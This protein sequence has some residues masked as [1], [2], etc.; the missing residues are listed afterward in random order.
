MALAVGAAGLCSSGLAPAQQE[1]QPGVPSQVSDATAGG[2]P[3]PPGEPAGAASK[4][5][6]AMKKAQADVERGLTPDYTIEFGDTDDWL[7]F[8]TGEWLRGRLRWVRAK[9]LEAGANVKFYSKQLYDETFG[10]SFVESIHCP[11]IMTY[12]FKGNISVSGKGMVTTNQVIIE[13]EQG[14]KTYPRSELVSIVDGA[15][16][17]RTWWSTQLSLGF[18]ANAGNTNQGSVNT[19][20]NL[21]RFDGRTAAYIGYNGSVGYADNA[22]NVN[23]H[24]VDF[25]VDLFL[26]PG[27]F[28]VIPIIGQLLYDE[29]QNYKLRAAPAAGG[30]VH[31][32]QKAKQ[33]RKHTNKFEWDI[34]SAL[35]YQFTRFLSSAT[36]VSNPQNDGF[37]MLRTYWKLKFVNRDV[38]IEIDWRTILVYT[39]FGNTN[40]NGT[41][42]VTIKITDR[43]DFEPSFLFLRTRDPLP[44]ADGTVPE[45]ND[46]QL[47]VSLALSLG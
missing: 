44:R 39:T 32:F 24:L 8:T 26:W 17:E 41:A 4:V 11:N 23:R 14:V 36:G 35:G 40:H 31:V 25:S 2:A 19:Q 34:E 16:R 3:A 30:G 28:Y 45:K 6:S 33:R 20:W 5:E 1:A 43:F 10:L 46:Y 29:F 21:L 37:V 47:V 15:P 12:G 7:Q 42:K 18:S 9:G 38:E 22:V 13:T 27:R